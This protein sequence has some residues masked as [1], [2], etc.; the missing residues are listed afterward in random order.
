V[1]RDDR[2]YAGIVAAK[3]TVRR[4]ALVAALLVPALAL[5]HAR[6]VSPAPRTT[7]ILKTPPCGG[8]GRSGL[9]TILAPGQ[10]VE[11]E[12]VETVD[13]PGHYELAFSPADDQGFVTLLGS[14]PD[15]AFASGAV[16]RTYTTTIQAP[17][18]PCEACTLQLIQFMS[19]HPPGSQYYY[20]CADIQIVAGVTT[21]TS[22]SVP[23]ASTTTSTTPTDCDGRIS[24]DRA[25]CLLAIAKAHPMCGGETLDPRLQR[26]LDAGFAMVGRRLDQAV[27][28]RTSTARAHRLVGAVLRRLDKLGRKVVAAGDHDRIGDPCSQTLLARLGDLRAAIATLAP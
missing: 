28:P 13:H 15:Y 19:D 7:T 17:S 26:A 18:T 2:G 12:W 21:S 14:I 27:V 25:T 24:Y 3:S 22:T 1:T 9:P 23:G 11:V 6:L 5:A 20:S 16:E 8:I 10:Q 4:G